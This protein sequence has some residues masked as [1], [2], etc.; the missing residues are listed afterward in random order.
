MKL[1]YTFEVMTEVDLSGD[2][3]DRVEPP[4][5]D[6]LVE[7]DY[8]YNIDVSVEDLAEYLLLDHRNEDIKHTLIKVLHIFGG[9]LE[10]DVD[11]A[12]FLT[13]KYEAAAREECE[14]DYE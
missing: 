2:Y 9:L 6:M 8:T 13:Q 3:Y 7:V 11:F 4:T 1:K 14:E 12:E 10:E 5:A